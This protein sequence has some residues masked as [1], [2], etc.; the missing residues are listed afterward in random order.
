MCEDD[1]PL[2]IPS[3]DHSPNPSLPLSSILH[4]PRHHHSRGHGATKS[5]PRSTIIPRPRNALPHRACISPDESVRLDE[6]RRHRP[7]G[8]W[9]HGAPDRLPSRSARGG[10]LEHFSSHILSGENAV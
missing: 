10:T 4:R 6:F 2:P 3:T 9:S 7:H 8:A 5:Y 1:G